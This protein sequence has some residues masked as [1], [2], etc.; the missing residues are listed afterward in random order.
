MDAYGA[1]P[2]A[3]AHQGI[4]ELFQAFLGQPGHYC[5]LH[6]CRILTIYLLFYCTVQRTKE[7]CPMVRPRA[8]VD[9]VGL[10]LVSPDASQLPQ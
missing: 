8:L 10:Q 2:P 6:A 1:I 9:D 3:E 5:G 7:I 4:W